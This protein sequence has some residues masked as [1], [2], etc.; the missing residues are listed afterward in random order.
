MWT[1][2][3]FEYRKRRV[4]RPVSLRSAAEGLQARGRVVGGEVV[5]AVDAVKV[6]DACRAIAVSAARRDLEGA[7]RA[8]VVVADNLR[9]AGGAG[10]QNR[11][12]QQ[13]VEDGSDAAG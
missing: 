5:S 10:G 11:L 13:E 3:S 7:L 6:G 2:P 8:V 12:A 9:A 4:A 1:R